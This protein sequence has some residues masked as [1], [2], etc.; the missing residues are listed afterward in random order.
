MAGLV[1]IAEMRIPASPSLISELGESMQSH[2]THYGVCFS[3]LQLLMVYWRGIGWILNAIQQKYRGLKETDP[4]FANID[5]R[6]EVALSDRKMIG[7]LLRHI[8]GGN[9]RHPSGIND[10]LQDSST[11]LFC[12]V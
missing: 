3:A 10:G 6:S 1:F 8:E 7:R 11:P 2:D 12:V 9:A 4:G 5:P